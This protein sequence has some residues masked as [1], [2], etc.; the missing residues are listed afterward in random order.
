L[1]A[2]KT[3]SFEIA[4]VI[5][6]AKEKKSFVATYLA[7]V[8]SLSEIIFGLIMVLGFTS[9]ARLAFGETSVE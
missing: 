9:T 3:R 4:L 5:D 8:D 2:Q 6:S 7:P 1:C